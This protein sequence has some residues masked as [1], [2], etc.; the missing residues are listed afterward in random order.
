MSRW[1]D[2]R[3]ARQAELIRTWR[4]WEKSTG[5]R[6][7]VGK[8]RTRMNGYKGG[9]RAMLRECSKSLIQALRE[10]R[11]GQQRISLEWRDEGNPE[12]G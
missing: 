10:Q 1:T 6:T 2:Q 11:Q 4:P 7:D 9:R 5:P 12:T 3:R 8:D